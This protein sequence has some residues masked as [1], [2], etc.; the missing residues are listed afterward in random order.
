MRSYRNHYVSKQGVNEH[1]DCANRWH[2][3]PAQV[4][5][6]AGK[7]A[8][9]LGVRLSACL[10]IMVCVSMCVSG[11]LAMNTLTHTKVNG[12]THGD[13]YVR[14][15]SRSSVRLV[16]NRKKKKKKLGCQFG[17]VHADILDRKPEQGNGE[18][19]ISIHNGWK[20]RGSVLNDTEMWEEN[21]RRE[22]VYWGREYH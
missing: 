22:E 3:K 21:E 15:P 18:K 1:T 8:R 20:S 11:G 16:L 14:I 5:V 19:N 13:L 9:V 12:M 2:D 7:Q 17:S 10:A 6:H 4:W